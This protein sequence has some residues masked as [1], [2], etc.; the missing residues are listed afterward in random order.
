LR[1]LRFDLRMHVEL[2]SELNV[3]NVEVRWF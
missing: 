3:T 1:D 2:D